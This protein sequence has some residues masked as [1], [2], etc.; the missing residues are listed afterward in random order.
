M[1]GHPR[2]Q[3]KTTQVT[4]IFMFNRNCLIAMRETT[5]AESYK[6]TLAKPLN[7]GMANLAKTV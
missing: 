3:I 4:K 1:R 2:N 7:V 5:Q 6:S